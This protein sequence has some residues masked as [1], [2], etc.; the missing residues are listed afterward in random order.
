MPNAPTQPGKLFATLALDTTVRLKGEISCLLDGRLQLSS[1]LHAGGPSPDGAIS[2]EL[3][4]A[5]MLSIPEDY[6]TQ[7]SL[8]EAPVKI[9]D[10]YDDTITL[11]FSVA[12]SELAKKYRE[13]IMER[14]GS[15]PAASTQPHFAQNITD[16][17]QPSLKAELPDSHETKKTGYTNTPAAGE[18]ARI[19]DELKNQSLE[20]L[21]D[22]LTPFFEDL[23]SYV[24]DIAS[25]RSGTDQGYHLGTASILERDSALEAAAILEQSGTL[26]E[27]RLLQQITRYF[28]DLTPDQSEDKLWQH[29]IEDAN[30]LDLIDLQQ[31]DEFLTIN[32]M[33]SLGERLHMLSLEALTIRLATLINAD[34]NHV[35]LP[36]HVR[37]LCRAFQR[38]LIEE[39]VPAAALPDMFDYFAKRFVGQLG[40]L[41]AALNSQLEEQ[42]ILPEIEKRIQTRGT[43]LKCNQPEQRPQAGRGNKQH[44]ATA[45]EGPSAD[46]LNLSQASPGPITSAINDLN[47]IYQELGEQLNGAIGNA[48]PPSLYRSVV[49]ALNFKREAD[50]LTGGET[51][52]SGTAISGTWEGGTVASAELDQGQLANAQSIA[53]ALSALQRNSQARQEVQESDSLRAYLASNRDH[54][55][56][57]QDTRGLT[58]DSLNQLNMVDNLFGTIKSQLDVSSDLKP[59]LGNLQIP[60][61]KL[62]LLD[63]DFFVDQTHTARNV[64]D[65]LSRLATSANF[66]NKALEDRINGIVDDIVDDYETDD[67][68]FASAL[69]RIEKLV[70]QQERALS[71]NIER[72]V[73]TQEGRQ[74]LADARTAVETAVS[75]RL[76]PP[77]APKVLVD[78]IDSGWRDLLV[79]THVREG[80]DSSAWEEQLKTLDLL[81]LWLDERQL[82]DADED[83]SVQRSLEAE[84]LIDLVNQQISSALPTNIAHEE[85]LEELRGILAGLIEIET[86]PVAADASTQAPA[87]AEVRAKIEDLPRLRRW[88]KRVEQLQLSSWLTYRDKSGG[89]KRMQL[90]WISPDKNRFIFVSERGQKV[91][92]LSAIKLARQLSQGVQPPAPADDLSVIDQ[93]MYHTLEH[94]QKSLSFAR[95]H[96]TLTKL[97]NLET[98]SVQMNRALR[99][100]QLKQSKHAVLFLNI[101]EFK[102]VNDVYDRITGDQVL[103]EFAKLLSQLHGK[104][105]SSSRIDADEFAV[106]LLE[107]S[108]DDALKI[109]EKIRNDIEASPLELEGEVVSFTV[110][111][112]VA[113][114][115]EHSRNVEEILDD[116]RSAMRHA[117]QGGRNRVIQFEETQSRIEDYKLEKTQTREDLESALASERF[118]LRAQPIVQSA[119][120]DRDHTTLHYELLLGLVNTDGSISSPEEFIRSAERYGLMSLVDQWVVKEA[121][122]W[123][124]QL[125]DEQKVVPN[126]AINLSGASVT[127]DAFMEYLLEQISEFGVG[128]SRLCFEITET[129]TISN[130]I[131]AADFVRAFRS[132]G[133]KF[134]IDDFGTGLASHN[135]LR[136][137]PVDYVKIDGSFVTGI[138]QNRNDYAM[139]RS[140]NDLAHFLGQKTIAESVENDAIVVKL[141]EIGVDYLQGWG[142]GMPKPLVEV[143]ADLSSLE[144]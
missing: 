97:I 78:L 124:S 112:G 110:S 81:C 19:V 36:I 68:I 53:K 29:S 32:R 77:S 82:A 58:A 12:D 70:A 48:N 46:T 5:G 137:L 27:Q 144:K 74:K 92:D 105:S 94:V 80:A 125:M 90:A 72:V 136:E 103:L 44:P 49:D 141:E 60:L 71:R 64:V 140:I 15:A 20:E 31:F 132:I 2:A 33:V 38:A 52:A 98:F 37:Q 63:P 88:V 111:I 123:I 40:E 61:T 66:P 120:S 13:A 45:S 142:V 7:H 99:H 135:Y 130:L 47:Q 83:H 65:K 18:Y 21:G 62:A 10:H 85:V 100:S 127:D 3:G 22:A 93:S 104:K 23:T 114:I 139:V 126:L 108:V 102:L 109:A 96:D 39:N 26:I 55:G 91:A 59:A 86:T 138:D 84:P 128:T 56:G 117:K 118:I 6:E 4:S 1:L 115:G 51:L 14:L 11:E 43:L 119:V 42:G 134:S 101:D 113:A 79:L 57:L 17:T 133:C 122:T 25:Q 9:A 41:Y 24:Q 67:S 50:G 73:R 131:K 107:C 54:I 116:A 16:D 95:N 87:P 69:R 143:T 76:P 89:K 28:L 75:S 34:P 121:F 8:A 35:R 129:G 30:E 106:L